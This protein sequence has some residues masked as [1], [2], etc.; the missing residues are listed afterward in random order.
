VAR[1]RQTRR[2]VE[3]MNEH[4]VKH[5]PVLDV[6]TCYHDSG[7]DCACRKPR[8]GLLLEAAQ[9]WNLHLQRSVMVG[10]RWSD[11]VAGQA[12]GC[13]SVLVVTPHSGAQRCRPDYGAADLVEA[14]AW[15]EESF[16]ALGDLA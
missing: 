9:R 14:V 15:I 7:D 11:I 5:L 8:P 12:A 13:T 1:G 4:V 6:L 10:D 2:R 3:E 16:P